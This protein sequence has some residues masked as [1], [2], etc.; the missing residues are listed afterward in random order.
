MASKIKKKVESG[1][2]VKLE[3]TGKF[4]DGNVF[5]SS[6][7]REPLEFEVDAKQ[8]IMGFNESVKG[9]KVGEE[10]EFKL[11]PKDAYGEPN[12]QLVQNIPRSKLP[13][14]LEPKVGMVLGLKSPD[15][16]Q[17]G[18]RIVDIGPE[19]FRIDLNHPLAGKNLNFKIKIVSIE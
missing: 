14:D 16:R 17:F 10:K 3:Y 2:K 12:P 1:S 6:E 19:T 18:A 7:G 11:A 15:G 5:D 9:M 4:D 13:Q 8:V